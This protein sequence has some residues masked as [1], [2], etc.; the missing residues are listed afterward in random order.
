MQNSVIARSA[1]KIP[2]SRSL[3]SFVRKRLVGWFGSQQ[4]EITAELFRSPD[5]PWV[6]CHLEIHG[7]GVDVSV[8][9]LARGPQQAL[10]ACADQVRSIFLS[11]ARFTP[12]RLA[13]A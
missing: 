6:R 12:L 9:E 7:E 5:S 13:T 11:R 10:D 3:Q 1:R 2:F 8:D 4:P